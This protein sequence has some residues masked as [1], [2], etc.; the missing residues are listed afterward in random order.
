MCPQFWDC[1]KNTFYFEGPKDTLQFIKVLTK[2][3]DIYMYTLYTVASKYQHKF[4]GLFKL[5]IYQN[6]Q[7]LSHLPNFQFSICSPLTHAGRRLDLQQPT[8]E[9][10]LT[11]DQRSLL[12]DNNRSPSTLRSREGSH[13]LQT[14]AADSVTPWSHLK[15][16]SKVPKRFPLLKPRWWLDLLGL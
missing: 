8:V 14:W 9:V 5:L 7:T 6:K 16:T 2:G 4:C 3:Q 10:Y 12:T 1:N 15:E 11:A 13:D